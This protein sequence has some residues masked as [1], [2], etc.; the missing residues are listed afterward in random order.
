MGEAV[1]HNGLDIG[2]STGTPVYA[3]STG[4]AKTV[5][6][7]D[8]VSGN[9]IILEHEIA[10]LELYTTQYLH[11]NDIY[12]AKGQQ[13]Q[14]GDLIGT[15]G[16]TGAATGPHLHF[17]VSMRK[18]FKTWLDPEPFIHRLSPGGGWKRPAMIAG[19]L[20][21]GLLTIALVWRYRRGR[22]RAT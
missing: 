1:N 19:A 5:V 18:P 22:V 4:K 8:R 14:E 11:L 7:G 2:A 16:M 12:I 6:Y 21:A 3:A 9:Y 17:N 20:S 10:G 15:V 13:V